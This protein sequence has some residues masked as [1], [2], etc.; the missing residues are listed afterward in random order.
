VY[1]TLCELAGLPAVKGLDGASFASVLKDPATSTK[2][3]IIHVYPRGER[4][5]R[6]IRTARY[7]LVEW[8][9]PGAPAD[10]AEYELYD[11]D[12]DPAESKN[13]AA[14]L[15]RILAELQAMLSKHPE[16]RPQLRIGIKSK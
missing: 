14:E 4:V 1:P 7:R 16:A 5:G 15:P 11:Y 2:E 6:A 9:K 10:S 13:L 12:A 3:A 8:K